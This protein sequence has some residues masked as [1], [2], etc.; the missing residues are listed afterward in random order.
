MGPGRST[1]LR[2]HE[3]R[4]ARRRQ[5][6]ARCRRSG[7][8]TRQRPIPDS[9]PRAAAADRAGR[10]PISSRPTRPRPLDIAR[11]SGL[12]GQR[13]RLGPGGDDAPT[14]PAPGASAV[15][16]NADGSF[17]YTPAARVSAASAPA[18]ALSIASRYTATDGRGHTGP[19]AVEITVRGLEQP[20]TATDVVPDPSQPS[21]YVRANTTTQIRPRRWLLSAASDPGVNDVLSLVGVAATSA[22]GATVQHRQRQSHLR[23]DAAC[24]RSSPGSGSPRQRPL[25]LHRDR[26]PGRDGFGVGCQV[27][28]QSPTQPAARHRCRLRSRSPK[29]ANTTAS[30][31]LKYATDPDALPGDPPLQAVAGTVTST[32]GATVTVAADGT[33][34]YDASTARTIL[35]LAPGQTLHDTVHLTRSPISRAAVGSRHGHADR[36]RRQAADP[37]RSIT[38]SRSARKTCSRKTSP[39][40]C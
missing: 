3:Q 9:C 18:R 27:I 25:H 26:P 34:K 29:T 23:P 22:A 17:T 33:F 32:H 30:S 13:H 4:A 6:R 20:P 35:A 39:T 10:F 37:R 15:K 14:R 24:R 31:L 2:L 1:R 38:S 19:A 21:L 8:Q 16:V 28:V 12:A 40:G 11:R 7:P 5:R 36:H